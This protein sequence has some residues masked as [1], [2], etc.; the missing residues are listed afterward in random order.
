ME[1]SPGSS[2]EVVPFG[3]DTSRLDLLAFLDILGKL[4]I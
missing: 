2:R 1:A 4:G 3:T